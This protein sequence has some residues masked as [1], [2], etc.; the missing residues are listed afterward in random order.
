MLTTIACA[1]CFTESRTSGPNAD[2][3]QI[4]EPTGVPFTSNTFVRSPAW[5][6]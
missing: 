4:T 3:K 5:K 1:P 6:S 2:S